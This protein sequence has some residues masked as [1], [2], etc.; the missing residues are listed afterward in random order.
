M[1]WKSKFNTLTIKIKDL[2]YSSKKSNKST[3]SGKTAL[4]ATSRMAFPQPQ[5]ASPVKALSS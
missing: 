3:M 5:A 4:E 1:K 2:Y